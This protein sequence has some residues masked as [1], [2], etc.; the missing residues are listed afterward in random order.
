MTNMSPRRIV[1]ALALAAS[2]MTAGLPVVAN[3]QTAPAPTAVHK[4]N[5]IQ[6]HPYATGFVAGVA[7][8][9]ALKVMAARDKARG[10][11][12]NWAERHPTLS[13]IGVGAVT[14]HEIKKH[15]PKDTMTTH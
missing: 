12:L 6:K 14:T 3:A 2:F 1:A 15:T 9:H 11:K 10:K 4:K 7:T 13:A 8:H 5:I